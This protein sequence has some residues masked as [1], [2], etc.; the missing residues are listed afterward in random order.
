MKFLVLWSQNLAT[1]RSA[2]EHFQKT[3]GAPPT[4]VTLTGRWFGMNGKG[5]AVVESDDPKA[6]F[7]YTAEWSE[8]LTIEVTP[9]V[10]DADAGEVLGA[11]FR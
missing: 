11:L 4:G 7:A 10:E 5:A 6:L 2:I 8:F 1:Y 9:L 3:G